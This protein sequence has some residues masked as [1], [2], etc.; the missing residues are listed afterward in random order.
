MLKNKIKKSFIKFPAIYRIFSSSFD[1][2]QRFRIVSELVKET[3][4]RSVLD[5]G[6]DAGHLRYFLSDLNITTADVSDKADFK[7][8]MTREYKLPFKNKEFDCVV[9]I[10]TFQ[11]VK[12]NQRQKFINELKRVSKKYIILAAP[13]YSKEVADAEKECNSFY[14]KIFSKD[15]HWFALTLKYGLPK[16]EEAENLIKKDNY[17]IFDNGYI[18]RWKALIKINTLLYS[19]CFPFALVFNGLYNILFYRYDNKEPGYRKIIFI[20]LR[21]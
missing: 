20:K 11:Y 10:D 3:D 2:Y 17:K 9:T 12:K 21:R 7:I 13:F 15:F 19:F 1:A 16:L 5:V 14:K 18:K 4:S 6:G 8:A